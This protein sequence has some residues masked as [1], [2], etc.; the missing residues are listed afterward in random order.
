MDPVL[1]CLIVLHDLDSIIDAV[2]N[3]KYWENLG[4]EKDEKRVHDLSQKRDEI[5]KRV[6]KPVLRQYERLRKRYH[7]GIAPVVGNTCMNCFSEL[8]TAMVSKSEK[9]KTVERCP[10]CGIFIYW[11]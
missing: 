2:S 9:N 6:P 10:S 11:G 1:E 4:L 5:A 7:R 8:P 3:P